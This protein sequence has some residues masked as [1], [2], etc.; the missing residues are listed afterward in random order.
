MKKIYISGCGGMLGEAFH[1]VFGAHHVLRCTDIDVNAPWLTYLDIRDL[2]A[3]RKDVSDFRPDYLFHLG[4]CTDLE[5]CE[6]NPQN[7]WLTNAIAAENAAYIANELDIPLLYIG[8][9]GIFDGS[10][11]L[12]D[13][14]D[15]PN[16]LSCYARSKYAGE[17]FI[18][19]HVVR[20]LVCRAGWMMG[21]GPAKDKKFVQKIMAQLADGAT[22]LYV[23]SDKFGSP[24]YTCDFAR[25][26]AVILEK[27]LWG[28]YNMACDGLTSRLEVAQFIVEHLGLENQ[29]RI[30]AVSSAHFEQAYFAK[31]PSSESL[32]NSKLKLRGLDRMRPWKVALRTYLDECYAPVD[33]LFRPRSGDCP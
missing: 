2:D 4:A 17:V 10:K 14:W 24:T 30:H 16:P 3:Y 8:T 5:D 33:R 18:R 27:E 12:F 32:V 11:Q 21:A 6:R 1:K 31:R 9:A 28:V 15:V 26:V 29:V 25:N 13:D 22:D 19:E 7:A 23:V 20:H